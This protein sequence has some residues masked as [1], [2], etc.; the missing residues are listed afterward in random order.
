MSN[1]FKTAMLLG[2]LSALLL[3]IGELLGGAQGLVIGFLFAV[4]TNFASYWFYDKIVLSMYG[5]QEADPDSRLVRTVTELSQP[6][7][8]TALLHHS[9]TVAE[10]VRDRTKPGTCGRRRH[11]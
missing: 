9:D 1:T 6:P 3:L 2:V 8:V 10:R 11:G 5:A 4:L 7:A